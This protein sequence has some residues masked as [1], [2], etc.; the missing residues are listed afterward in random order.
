MRVGVEARALLGAGGS[1]GASVGRQ[2][3]DLS[4]T[5]GD[6]V[7]LI[8]NRNLG[9]PYLSLTRYDFDAPDDPRNDRLVFS[10]GIVGLSVVACILLV[11]FRAETVHLLPLY[12]LGVFSTLFLVAALWVI[13]SFEPERQKNFN[14]TFKAGKD[15]DALRPKLEPVGEAKPPPGSP[16]HCSPAGR[17]CGVMG[18]VCH[19]FWGGG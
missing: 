19:G 1:A 18:R 13:E 5:E 10:N 17:P 3:Q 15:T 7:R 16:H 14:L 8:R 12:A 6:G 4:T 2:R 9:G 11:L